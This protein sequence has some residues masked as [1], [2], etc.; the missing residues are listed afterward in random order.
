MP[1]IPSPFSESHAKT[2][3]SDIVT[4]HIQREIRSRGLGPGERIC[5]EKE[6]QAITGISRAG[7]R[8]ALRT[9][10]HEGLIR[11]KTGPGG[12]ILVGQPAIAP[13]GRTVE[14]FRHLAGVEPAALVDAWLELAVTC[15][16]L[17][18]SR[19]TPDDV[20]ALRQIADDYRALNLEQASFDAVARL[21]LGFVRRTAQAAQNPI[22]LL[23]LDA[24]IDLIYSAAATRPPSLE[25]RREL[26]S[27][28]DRVVDA[29]QSGDGDAAARRMHRHLSALR[30]LLLD[31]NNGPHR[32]G[33]S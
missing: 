10:E 2:R 17:A 18:A 20:E 5:S 7:V 21:N 24:L 26:V 29:L 6:L 23:F 27:V 19:A 14:A 28:H 32:G 25:Q 15:A 22:L 11:T 13:L 30:L 12:G 4:A 8:E 1:V 9:L 31:Q 16:R 33:P 3:A